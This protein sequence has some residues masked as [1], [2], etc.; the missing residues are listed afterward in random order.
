VREVPLA[1]GSG[2]VPVQFQY[3]NAVH[4]PEGPIPEPHRLN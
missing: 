4:G 2:T 1:D 3:S